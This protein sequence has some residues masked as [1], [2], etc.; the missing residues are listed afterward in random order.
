MSQTETLMYVAKAMGIT[1]DL[2]DS[3]NPRKVVLFRGHLP[4]YESWNP[5]LSNEDAFHVALELEMDIQFFTEGEFPDHVRVSA[6]VG[7]NATFGFIQEFGDDKFAAT[8]RAIVAVA[9][10]VGR[11]FLPAGVKNI[12]FE[13]LGNGT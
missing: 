7:K 11:R 4:N 3:A 10:E 6:K 13:E 2:E 1:L 5:S 12:W 8:R 9:E